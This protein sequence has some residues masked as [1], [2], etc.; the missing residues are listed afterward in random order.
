MKTLLDAGVVSKISHGVKLLGKGIENFNSLNK[1]LN[2]EISD[3]SSDALQAVKDLGGNVSMQY[4]T[5]LILRSHLKPHKFSDKREL[6]IPMPHNKA[7]KKL[8]RLERKGIEVK[9]PNAPWYSDNKD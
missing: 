3:A 8:E 4:R 7:I 2:I 1:P 9:M 6:K 5:D